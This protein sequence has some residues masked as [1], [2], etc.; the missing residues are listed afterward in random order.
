MEQ[1]AYFLGKDLS[2]RKDQEPMLTKELRNLCE[3]PARNF[4]F[5]T[6]IWFPQNWIV[7]ELCLG[8][9]TIIPT[10][11]GESYESFDRKRAFEKYQSQSE[12]IK[13]ML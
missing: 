8:E 12:V 3:N 2:F 13:V 9:S 1:S 10:Q 11:I 5:K 7:T 4:S 6:Q